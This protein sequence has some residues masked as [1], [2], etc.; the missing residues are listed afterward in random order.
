VRACLA[1][2]LVGADFEM[3]ELVVYTIDEGSVGECR[4]EAPQAVKRLP[5]S[6]IF[7]SLS[8]C[9]AKL[10]VDKSS[11]W[12]SCRS[13]RRGER[14]IQRVK[15][16]PQDVPF[17]STLIHCPFHP[18]R[19]RIKASNHRVARAKAFKIWTQETSITEAA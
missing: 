17:C 18:W 4:G 15:I 19:C 3:F 2:G 9:P 10:V 13:A 1:A 16:I 6:R 5:L 14:Q 8:C 12:P 11:R 7:R